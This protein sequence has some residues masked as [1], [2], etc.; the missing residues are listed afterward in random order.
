MINNMQKS[1][2]KTRLV[3]TIY[4][5]ITLLLVPTY[6]LYQG[7]LYFNDNQREIEA[8]K[9]SQKLSSIKASLGIHIDQEGFLVNHLSSLFT[10]T[11]KPEDFASQLSSFSKDFNCQIDYIIYTNNARHL[12][13]NFLANKKEK[14]IW[15]NMAKKLLKIFATA[16]ENKRLALL[17]GLRKSLGFNFY[18]PSDIFSNEFVATDLFQSDFANDE[19]RYWLASKTDYFVLV[20]IPVSELSKPTGLKFF[21]K[22]I[23][24]SKLSLAIIKDNS[25]SSCEFLP[26][27]VRHA[28]AKLIKN[29]EQE[30]VQIN[31]HL[32]SS[33][34]IRP[35]HKIIL[36]Y[37][38]PETT[39]KAGKLTLLVF[40][41][42]TFTLILLVRTGIIS[43]RVQ[44]LSLLSQL[45]ILMGVSAGIPLLV[46]CLMAFGYLNN[47]QTALIREKKKA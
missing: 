31:D 13:D 20:R 21:K 5:F 26:T 15:N 7:L 27:E 38:L 32:F 18:L 3:T 1:S 34:K 47:K 41:F 42:T 37:Q 12:T 25:I 36:R 39:V 19:C 24:Q 30:F 40:L 9:A 35:G 22:N 6:G 28:Q 8:K 46:L 4:L 29:I 43:D 14:V 16:N 45:F 23:T 17:N 44:D 10:T 2:N 11:A 33:L